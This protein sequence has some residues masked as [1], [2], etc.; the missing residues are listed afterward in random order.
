M[1]SHGR[2]EKA[3]SKQR[4]SKEGGTSKAKENERRAEEQSELEGASVCNPNPGGHMPDV[5]CETRVPRAP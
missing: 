3:G 5:P 4:R 2:E 1:P